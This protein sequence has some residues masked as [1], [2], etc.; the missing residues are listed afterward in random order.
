MTPEGVTTNKELEAIV[1]S[2]DFSRYPEG[3][4]KSSLRTKKLRQL[5]EAGE[6]REN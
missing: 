6:D 5:F 4:L 2:N 3:R 1:C